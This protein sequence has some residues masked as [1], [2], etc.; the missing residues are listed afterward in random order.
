MA[1]FKDNQKKVFTYI[2]LVCIVSWTTAGVAY[3]CGMHEATGIA[4]QLFAAFYMLLPAICAILLQKINREPVFKNLCVSFKLNWWLLVALFTPIVIAFAELGTSLLLPN[5]SFSTTYDSFLSKLPADTAEIFADKLLSYPPS[6]FMLIQVVQ[7]LVAGCTINAF[8][9]FGEELGWRGYLL[10]ALR[11]KKFLSAVLLIGT[12]WGLWHLPLIL[13]GHN[14]PEHPV[15]G[16][17]MMT[18]MC[19]LL[20]PMMIYIVLKSRSVITAAVFHGV[21]NAIA[22]IGSLYIVGGND[23]ICGVT[24]VTG[25]FVLLIFNVAFYIYDRYIKQEKLFSSRI[26]KL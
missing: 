9:A 15:A 1:Q 19:I 4:Y 5:V 26:E 3:L 10:N 24:G 14:Y 23:L 7:A 17:G 11:G 22:G 13:M 6:F 2:I 18:V 21:F 20:S 12:V 8:F 16:V 25:L